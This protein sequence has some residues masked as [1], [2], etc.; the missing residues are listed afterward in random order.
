MDFVEVYK[1]KDGKYFE[2]QSKAVQYCED[3]FGEEL[4][5]LLKGSPNLGIQAKMAIMRAIIAKPKEFQCLAEWALEYQDVKN[6]Q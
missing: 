2:S 6:H 5:G 1:T 3:K 4:D